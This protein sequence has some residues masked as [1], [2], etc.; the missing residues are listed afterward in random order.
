MDVGS[1]KL[2]EFYQNKFDELL[3]REDKYKE[4]TDKYLKQLIADKYE[5]EAEI[6]RKVEKISDLQK[7]LVDL[8]LSCFEE[9]ARFLNVA[10]ENERLKRNEELLHKNIRQLLSHSKDKDL[11][12]KIIYIL[13]DPNV[14][15]LSRHVEGT[16]AGT[17][18][19]VTKKKSTSDLLKDEIQQLQSKIDE[20]SKISK[21]NSDVILEDCRVAL[22]KSKEKILED[23]QEIRKLQKNLQKSESEIHGLRSSQSTHQ[24]QSAEQLSRSRINVPSSSKSDDVIHRTSMQ[25]RRP[26]ASDMRD[27][28]FSL[29][30]VTQISSKIESLLTNIKSSDIFIHTAKQRAARAVSKYAAETDILELQ[31]C[32]RKSNRLTYDIS[33]IWKSLSKEITEQNMTVRQR[34]I[35]QLEASITNLAVSSA[36]AEMITMGLSRAKFFDYLVNRTVSLSD[37]EDENDVARDHSKCVA[38]VVTLGD[39]VKYAALS[40]KTA[41]DIIERIDRNIDL[42]EKYESKSFP[43]RRYEE[44]QANT[45][46][47]SSSEPYIKT[48]PGSNMLVD[49]F[50][51]IY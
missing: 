15:I 46:H 42:V 38:D 11:R 1:K 33:N 51:S 9:K 47:L 18:S 48:V 40:V 13:Q 35:Q 49:E 44:N 43:G 36:E 41:T 10:D 32:V 3:K 6:D 27:L 24:S 16:S 37:L 31:N 28:K 4:K 5:L 21:N 23:E 14:E 30:S 8:Q 45:I 12:D 39:K 17:S 2:L 26:L 19:S 20:Y 7:A 25:S 22:E 34:D 29:A 50:L